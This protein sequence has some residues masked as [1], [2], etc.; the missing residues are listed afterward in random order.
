[1]NPT[2]PY[3]ASKA[4]AECIIR[5]YQISFQLP[6]V[7]VRPSNVYGPRQYPEKVIPRFIQQTL[8]GKAC[9]VHDD[10]SA[11]RTF[12]YVSDIVGGIDAVL[13]RGKV[14]R[15]YCLSGDEENTMSMVDVA[16]AVQ[17]TILQRQTC[18]IEYVKGHRLFNDKQYSM[19]DEETR[20][21]GWRPGVSFRRG[22][23]QTV[24]WYRQYG[25]YWWSP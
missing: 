10:G 7:I 22:L 13:W 16:R 9:S 20:K 23:E 21:L 5:S 4:I 2:S 12:I 8:A 17:E 11:S 24:E 14:G 3:A 18:N 15:V 25:E 1:M 19:N 6:V